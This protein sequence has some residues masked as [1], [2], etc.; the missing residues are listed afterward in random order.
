MPKNKVSLIFVELL[1]VYRN[2]LSHSTHSILNV[3]TFHVL[4]LACSAVL[5]SISQSS[6]ICFLPLCVFGSLMAAL[7]L[8][9]ESTVLH[10]TFTF[11]KKSSQ[12]QTC[13]IKLIRDSKLP[14]GV[15]VWSN[16]LEWICP[17]PR[18]SFPTSQIFLVPPHLFNHFIISTQKHTKLSKIMSWFLLRNDV[19]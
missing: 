15:N 4:L 17:G 1:K 3:S 18:L 13:S 10:M 12:G 9:G 5:Y 2:L 14:V 6:A 8:L 11:K 19:C 7:L 16:G